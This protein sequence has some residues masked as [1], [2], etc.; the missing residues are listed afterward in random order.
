MLKLQNLPTPSCA[1]LFN[2]IFQALVETIALKPVESSSVSELGWTVIF[3]GVP[4]LFLNLWTKQRCR[5]STY[6]I[7]EIRS[8][9]KLLRIS[10]IKFLAEVSIVEHE[11]VECSLF[12]VQTIGH[13]RSRTIASHTL[14]HTSSHTASQLHLVPIYQPKQVASKLAVLSPY[15]EL[16][17]V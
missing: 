15:S 14:G 13:T 4:P 3:R 2:N 6:Q 1:N 11:I 16:K 10:L 17:T 5:R 9:H 12:P 8:V 7:S